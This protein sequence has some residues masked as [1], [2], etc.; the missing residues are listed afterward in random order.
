MRVNANSAAAALDD[1][2]PWAFPFQLYPVTRVMHP[3]CNLHQG[4]NDLYLCYIYS[5]VRIPTV[6][7][8]TNSRISFFIETE[9]GV[10]NFR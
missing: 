4:V 10:G 6:L 9:M 5:V 2:Y 3:Q 7:P 8:C 1:C